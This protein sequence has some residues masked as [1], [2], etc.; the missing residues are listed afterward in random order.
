MAHP[1]TQV[2]ATK[3]I[4]L[5]SCLLCSMFVLFSETLTS[6]VFINANWF[7]LE[8]KVAWDYFKSGE[9]WE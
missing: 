1:G 5:V 6:F 2:S 9:L 8:E 7:P 3:E 4:A